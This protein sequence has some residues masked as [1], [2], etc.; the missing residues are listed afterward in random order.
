MM[1]TQCPHCH[2]QAFSAWKKIGVGPLRRVACASCGARLSV[3]RWPAAVGVA[4]IAIFPVA[5]AKVAAAIVPIGPLS[6]TLTAY[7][8][9]AIIIGVP[10]IWAYAKYVPLVEVRDA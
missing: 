1:G 8:I 2:R 7:L 3:S 9:S 6:E 4:L 5:S 10:I